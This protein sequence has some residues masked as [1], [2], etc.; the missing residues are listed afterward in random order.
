MSD[1]ISRDV[2]IKMLER[3]ETSL[4]KKATQNP[5]ASDKYLYAARQISVIIDD[6]HAGLEAT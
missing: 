1:E 5:E 6:I 3:R 2:I 4:R